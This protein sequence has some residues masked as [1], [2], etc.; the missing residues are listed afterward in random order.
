MK[1]KLLTIIV[2][3]LVILTSGCIKKDKT[4]ALDKIIKRDKLIVGTKFDTKPFGFIDNTGELKGFDIDL[5]KY[6]AKSILGDENKIEFKQ[7]TPS[8]RILALNSGEVDMVIATMTMTNQRKQII[9]FSTPYYIAGQAVLVPKNSKIN[10]I[11]DL[12]GKRVIIIFGSTSEK[13]L[14]MVAPEAQ[15]IGFKTY[16]SGYSALKSGRAD[17]MTSDDVI[18]MGFAEADPSFKLLPQ[19]YTKEPYAI[20]FRKDSTSLKLEE[21]V[22]SI[23]ESMKREGKLKEIQNKWI[24][25]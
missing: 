14:R 5:A 7:V 9:D 13:N 11:S 23:L 12:N 8:N 6:I 20:A 15:I 19:K 18:L 2:L 17:A 21:R 4:D 10:S 24:K 3:C 1:R 25:S 16:T 22:E